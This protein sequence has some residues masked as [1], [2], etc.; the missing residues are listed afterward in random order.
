MQGNIMKGVIKRVNEK[1]KVVPTVRA[2]TDVHITVR[3]PKYITTFA[4]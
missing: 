1:N 3:R 4:T 2:F